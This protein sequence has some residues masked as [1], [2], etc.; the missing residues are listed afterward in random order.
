MSLGRWPVTRHLAT[1]SLADPSSVRSSSEG[2][3][4]RLLAS[5]VVVVGISLVLD[6]GDDL[7]PRP[8]H[9]AAAEYD[10]WREAVLSYQPPCRGSADPAVEL[11]VV[12]VPVD[13]SS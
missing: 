11:H 7:C 3:P 10:G 13:G 8:E 2:C 6:E 5:R 1:I 4:Q 9:G 12:D